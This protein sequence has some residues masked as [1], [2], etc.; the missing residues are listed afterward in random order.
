MLACRNAK[1]DGMETIIK[2]LLEHKDIDVNKQNND[3][4]TALMLACRYSG[5]IVQKE[6]LKCY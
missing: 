3:G 6:L 1:K 5:K 4:C 2:M